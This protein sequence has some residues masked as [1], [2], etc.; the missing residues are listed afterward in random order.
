[1]TRDPLRADLVRRGVSRFTL[2]AG[3]VATAG[4]VLS[5]TLVIPDGAPLHEW[6]GLAQR[7]TILLVLFPARIV[8]SYRLLQVTRAAA[9]S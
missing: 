5:R 8:L 1:M 2:V 3:L 9:A 4:L 6:A 7:L